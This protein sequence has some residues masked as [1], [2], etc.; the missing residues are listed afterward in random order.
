MC[1]LHVELCVV[2]NVHGERHGLCVM[3]MVRGMV[4][5]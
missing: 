1:N 5:V 4:Y 3:Y 2:C